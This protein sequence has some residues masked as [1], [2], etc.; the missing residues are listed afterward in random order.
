M[1]KRRG[2]E[3]SV[4]MKRGG[5]SPIQIHITG[6]NIKKKKKGEKGKR[7]FFSGMGEEGK[8]TFAGRGGGTHTLSLIRSFSKKEKEKGTDTFSLFVVRW[9]EKRKKRRNKS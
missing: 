3:N 2:R 8:R 6:N 7:S 1:R 4:H 5:R 9:K